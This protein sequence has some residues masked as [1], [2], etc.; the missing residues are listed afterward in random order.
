MTHSKLHRI[1]RLLIAIP[2]LAL[3]Y[4]SGSNA[5]VNVTRAASPETALAMDPDDAAALA[6]KT[7]KQW[8]DAA[9]KGKQIDFMPAARRSLL[10]A[11]LNARALRLYGLGL[12]MR[13]DRPKVLLLN[14]TAVR[15]SRREGGAQLWLMEHAVE[16]NDIPAV[17]A[18]YDVML[19]TN[20]GM[21]E[22]LHEKLALGLSDPEI[23]NAFVPYV[24]KAPFWL[25]GFLG[26]ALVQPN[27]DAL[28]YAIRQAGGLPRTKAYGPY[29]T[30]LLGQLFARG[31][32]EEARAFYQSL[33]G[34]DARNLTSVAFTDA[35]FDPKFA[36]VSWLLESN[37]SVGATLA[38]SGEERAINAFALSGAL[39][40][41][42][43]KYLFL[44]PGTYR[45]GSE[46]RITSPSANA[47][48]AWVLRCASSADQSVIYQS[49]IIRR[50]L[51]EPPAAQA[52]ITENCPVQRLELSL[53]GGDDAEGLELQ[54]SK[55]TIGQ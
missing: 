12:D 53:S 22:L 32:F 2:V 35:A 13:G 5:I 21:G 16:R 17:L 40:V 38:K 18:H 15:V 9:A 44:R 19:S 43:S 3:A 36:P 33:P 34:S 37:S 41:A 14:Q 29:S 11:G 4:L 51:S 10:A 31:K 28:S 30:A 55:V 45:F 48:A 39:G 25:A 23:R 20:A 42:A 27:P 50:P 7:D 1:S 54:V 8:T 52:L 49:E 24:R 6:L 47:R 26:N 46:H